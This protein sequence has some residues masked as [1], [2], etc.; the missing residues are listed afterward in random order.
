MSIF[1]FIRN[2]Q[3]D[4]RRKYYKKYLRKFE[5]HLRPILNIPKVKNKPKLFCIGFNKTGTTSLKTVFENHGFVI[6]NQ[7]RGEKLLDHY[8]KSQFEPIIRYCRTGE[9]FQDIPFSL[10]GTYT[11]LE[12]AFPE[13]KFVLSVRDT[14]EEW[15]LS[16]VRFHSKIFGKGKVP[17]SQDLKG[18][19]YIHKGW[20]W[21]Y[22][23]GAYKTPEDDPYEKKQLIN[24]YNAHNEA[25]IRYFADKPGKLLVINLKDKGAFR[26]FCEFVNIKTDK[27]DFPWANKSSEVRIRI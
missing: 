17:T 3:Y 15:Y 24:C 14:P 18:H 9:V 12:R 1:E 7:W 10:P 11:Y 8:L 13:A 23:H 25:V 19:H 2:K 6:G 21:K 4:I 20:V 22:I 16:L 27:N 5:K 26:E